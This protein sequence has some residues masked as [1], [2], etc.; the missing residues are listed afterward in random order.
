ME[1]ISNKC[2]CGLSA[3][4]LFKVTRNIGDEI[5]KKGKDR[6]PEEDQELWDQMFHYAK[7]GALLGHTGCMQIV[8]DIYYGRKASELRQSKDCIGEAV[9]W[10]G[11]AAQEGNG[12]A[13]TNLGLLYLN[14]PIPGTG[15]HG[16]P[17]ADPQKALEYFKLGHEL[18]D[19]KA[20]RHV[21]L[22]YKNGTVVEKDDKL[23]YEWFVKA[24]ERGDSS[25]KLYVADCKLKGEGTEQNIPA[26]IEGYE[27]LV[28]KKGHDIANAAYRLGCIYRDGVFAEKDIPRSINY[29]RIVVDNATVHERAIAEDSARMIQE[30]KVAI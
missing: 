3:E 21:G 7:A 6:A 14:R 15:Y 27:A 24:A 22:C 1:D 20:G 25:A 12:Q 10:W 28:E 11:K 23:A 8:A 9:Y 30:L 18:G 29:F 5:R 17:Q 2:D 13:A 4:D 16:G 19:M 26:A